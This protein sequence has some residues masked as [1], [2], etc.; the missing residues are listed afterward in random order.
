MRKSLFLIS[1]LTPCIG[2]TEPQFS[3]PPPLPFGEMPPPNH[4]QHDTDKDHLPGF[5]QGLDLSSQQQTDLKN[6]QKTT[7][8]QIDAKLGDLK[9]A[10]SDVHRLSFSRDFSEEKIKALIE[11]SAATHQQ[12]ALQKATLDHAIYEIL[13]A[14]QRQKLQNQF[15]QFE[16]AHG[17]K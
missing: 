5:L 3:G 16:E 11:K 4:R 6:L 1:L 17:K 15:S 8:S 7:F 13:T 2:M 10:E 14:E 9:K 12:L